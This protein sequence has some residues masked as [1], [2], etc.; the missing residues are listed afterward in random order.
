MIDISKILL[1]IRANRYFIQ[2]II[3]ISVLLLF[4]QSCRVGPDYSRPSVYSP[5][6]YRSDF[7]F[8]TTIANIPWWELFGDTVLQRMIRT[9]LE[10]NNNLQS[11]IA[12]IKEAESQMGIVRADLYPRIDYSADGIAAGVSIDGAS[13]ASLTPL[14]SV[15]YE[16]D[17]WGKIHRLSESALQQ[18]LATE[19]AY[20]SVT[21]GLVASVAISYLQL[22]DIDNR[23][24]IAENTAK[25]WQANLDIVQARNN[26]GIVSDVDVNQAEIQLDEALVSIETNERLRAQ[27][28]N[29]ISILL[30]LPPQDIPRGLELNKQI[31]PPELPVGLPSDI[32]N[33]RPDI[34][35][36][37]NDLHAQ[38]EQIGVAEALK[39]PQLI[40]SANLGAQIA[41][42][43]AVFATL[44]AQLLGPL[45]N[46]KANRQ[47]VE[48]EIARTEQLLNN[49]EET[50]IVA[51]QEVEDA[52]VAVQRYGNEYEIR[53]RQMASA[54]NAVSLSWVRYENGVTNYLEILDLQRSEFSAQLQASQALQLQL[55]STINLYK[56]LGGGWVPGQDTIYVREMQ[57]INNE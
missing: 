21:I 12:R 2:A 4:I 28:E 13:Y 16:V 37:E 24:L 56:A 7:P 8:D 10:N 19:E 3:F 36:A 55:T 23:L 52:M 57:L 32:L 53:V 54:Q 31:F 18:Y 5:E 22:R 15:S 35:K 30:G 33:R 49:Y 45:F 50:F 27:T 25:I 6:L 9:A 41:N 51:L 1:I 20:R 38:S 14:A 26:A 40:L 48:V 46:A 11:A 39:Y 44:G 17:L 29:G 34:M 47:R 42:P 43:T